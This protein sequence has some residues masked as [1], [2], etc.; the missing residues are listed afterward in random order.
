MATPPS[1][2]EEI[3][4]FQTDQQRCMDRSQM[5]IARGTRRNTCTHLVRWKKKHYNIEVTEKQIPV[6]Q[7]GATHHLGTVTNTRKRKEKLMVL[8]EPD[9]DLDSVSLGSTLM[10]KQKSH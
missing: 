6:V 3:M 7:I 4:L 2:R 5:T 8:M 10:D 9:I 1:V